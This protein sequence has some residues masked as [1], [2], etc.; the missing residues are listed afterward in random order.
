M[1]YTAVNTEYDLQLRQYMVSVYNNMGL[2]LLLSGV[3]AYLVSATPALTSFFF[4]GAQ[5]YFWIL[6]PLGMALVLGFMMHKFSASTVKL[7]FYSY[8]ALM[9]ISLATVFMTF[10]LGSIYQ[11]FLI[12]A[13]V[14]GITSIYGYVTKRDLTSLGSFMFM[15]LI[16]LIIASLVNLFL[17]STMLT[18]VISYIGVIVFVGLTAYDTQKIKEAFYTSANEEEMAKSG[19]IGAMMLYLDFVNLMM[20]FL[21]IFGEKKD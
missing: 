19:I 3:I 8:A 5:A 1:N 17:Q 12:T 21:Q 4:G 11:V 6:A 20:S 9:G 15:G 10:K 18:F 7:L 16:G 14:F 2:G 13:S